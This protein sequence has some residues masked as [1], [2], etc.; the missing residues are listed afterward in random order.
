MLRIK[1]LVVLFSVFLST[2]YCMAQ[3]DPF[4]VSQTVSC[5]D[6]VEEKLKL[7][8]TWQYKGQVSKITTSGALINTFWLVDE[9]NNWLSIN[10]DNLPTNFSKWTVEKIT[11]QFIEWSQPLPQYCGDRI[12]YIM[13]FSKE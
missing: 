9:K 11:P 4:T 7:I 10:L 12:D 6:F 2:Q 1:L 3:N 8:K 13:Y 5:K